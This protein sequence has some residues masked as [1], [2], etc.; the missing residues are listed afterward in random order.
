MMCLDET[1]RAKFKCVC[2]D[3]PNIVLPTKS[4]TPGSIQ[5]TFGHA[6]LG[7]MYIKEIVTD[8]KLSG[9]LK[10]P[11][12]LSIDAECTF[13]SADKNIRL[14]IMEILL[15]VAVSNLTRSNK[16]LHWAPLI[17]ALL[18]LFL[19]D[20]VVLGGRTSEAGTLKNFSANIS[21]C[22]LEAV[23]DV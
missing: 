2:A 6:S 20:S 12:V 1:A 17:A 9:P 5:F 4:A 3:S 8:F 14:L 18:P 16:M 15:R 19:T 21:E 13:A 23:V 22:G 11:M 7:N 10:S